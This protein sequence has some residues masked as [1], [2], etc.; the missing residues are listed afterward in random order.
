VRRKVH[1]EVIAILRK[2]VSVDQRKRHRDATRLKADLEAL[3]D[4]AIR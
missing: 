1:P 2:A 4:D 3:G